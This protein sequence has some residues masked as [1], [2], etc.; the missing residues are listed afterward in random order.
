MGKTLELAKN[1]GCIK[2]RKINNILKTNSEKKKQLFS[3]FLVIDFEATCWDRKPGPPNEVIEFPAVLMN[4]K[5]KVIKT[6]HHYVQPTE[7]PNLSEFCRN[8]TGISQEQVENAAPLGS[9]LM[10][11][12]TFLKSLNVKF[13]EVDLNNCA[14][15]TW[16]DWDMKICLGYECKRKNLLFPT[17]LKSW[18]DLK[19]IY[20]KFYNRNP[21]GLNG[22]LQEMGL[23]F[24]GRQHSGLCDAKNTGKLVHK[25]IQDGCIL[26]LTKCLDDVKLDPK[27]S[28]DP[29][30]IKVM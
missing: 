15:V 14:V 13:N 10:L 26:G 22:A 9:V 4:V 25:M 24:Q 30:L 19:L 20:K 28:F 2:S 5:G 3:H 7:E 29:E 27:L 18:I 12:N 8:L 17:C 1:Q 23:K 11:F 16:T 21:Q 6:F